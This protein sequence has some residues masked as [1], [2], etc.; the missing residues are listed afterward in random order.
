MSSF[1][2]GNVRIESQERV[3]SGLL[4]KVFGLLA[5]TMAFAAAGGVVGSR[6]PSSAILPM[7]F[8]QLGLIIAVQRFREKE[9]VNF[10]LLYAF[11]FASGL[12]LGPI[13]A[14]YVSDGLGT[15]VLQA[16][17]V[18]G[19]TTAAMGAFALTTKRDLSGLAPYLFVGVIALLAAMILNIFVG[20]ATAYMAISW[21]GAMLFCGFLAYDIQKVRYAPDT[22]GSAVMIALSIYLDVVNLFMFVLRIITGGRR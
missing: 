1:P 13:L 19:V 7:F 20:G 22:M 14:A 18:T 16:A 9:G 6:L 10:I 3:A 12:M 17:G 21:V 2:T 8:V 5:F 15:A 4:A 11:A